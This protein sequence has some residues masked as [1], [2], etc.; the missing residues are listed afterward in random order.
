MAVLETGSLTRAAERLNV[1]QP[2]VSRLIAH[3]Q[4]DLG[5]QLFRRVGARIVPTAEAEVVREDVHEALRGVDRAGRRLQQLA[6]TADAQLAVTAFPALATTT[7]P[8]VLSTFQ[9]RHPGLRVSL[10]ATNTQPRLLASV[11]LQQSDFAISNVPAGSSAVTAEHLCRYAAVCVVRHDHALADRGRVAL[12]EAARA[13]SV[14][15]DAE[16][17][18]QIIIGRAC[19]EAGIELETT[20]EVSHCAAAC[21]WV[22]V[23]GGAA[24]VDPFTGG[25]WRGQLRHVDT[26]PPIWLDLWVLRPAHKPLSRIA[27]ACLEDLRTYL[28]SRPELIADTRPPERTPRRRTLPPHG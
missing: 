20:V 15:L 21:A 24:I 13:A 3:L 25:E 27:S 4:A 23:A 16:D 12:T 5:Y 9:A 10:R 11:A 14:A 7:L 8:L 26:D 28:S 18:S 17:D 19:Q 1:S 2:A 6:G 22:A